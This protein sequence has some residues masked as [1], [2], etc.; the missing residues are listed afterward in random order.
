MGKHLYTLTLTEAIKE[1]KVSSIVQRCK[2]KSNLTR[3][4]LLLATQILWAVATPLVKLSILTPYLHIFGHVQYMRWTVSGLIVFTIFWT[5]SICLVLGLQCRPIQLLWDKT[6]TGRRIDAAT[7]FIS[8]SSLDVATDFIILFLPMPVVWTLQVPTSKKAMISV[9][10]AIGLLSVQHNTTA[11]AEEPNT[12]YA[13]LVSSAL[14]E[15]LKLHTLS[16]LT[17]ILPVSFSPR[18]S[19]GSMRHD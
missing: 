17:R 14:S 9:I 11:P 12:H 3:L 5:V 19:H 6:I 7:F 13:E 1:V 15:S 16:K 2:A 18:S 10:F 4:K 8:A